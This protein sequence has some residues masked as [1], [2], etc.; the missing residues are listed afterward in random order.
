MSNSLGTLAVDLVANVAQFRKEMKDSSKDTEEAMKRIEGAVELG[1]KALEVLGIGLSIGAFA[2]LIKGSIDA[3][4]ELRDMSQKTGVAVETLNGLAF[5]AGQAGGSMEAMADGATKLNKAVAEAGRGNKDFLEPF[6]K[7]GI[8]IR[9]AS[10]QLKTADVLMAE[11]ADNF[12]KY[13]DGPEKTAIALRIFEDAG[14]NLIPLLNDGGNAM[15]ENIEYAKKYSGVTQDLANASDNFNDTL[16]KLKI[17]QKGFVNSMTTSLLPV[18]QAVADEMLD[19]AEK[20]GKFSL[21]GAVLRTILETIV[22]VGSEA[23]FGFKMMGMAIGGMAAEVK[24]L[25]SADMKGFH[26]ISDALA[27]DIDKAKIEHDAF[28]KRVLNRDIPQIALPETPKSEKPEKPKPHAPTLR[29]TGDDPAQAILD[30]KLK[31]LEGAY[32]K[33]R[34]AA[35]FHAR[36]MQ[37]LR[38]QDLITLIA[39]EEDRQAETK[40]AIEASDKFYDAE[41]AAI[42]KARA[43]AAKDADRTSL[44]NQM[45][46]KV[47]AK[48]KARID[49]QNDAT[50]QTLK[51]SSAQSE[52]N[53]AMKEWTIQQDLSADQF[54]FELSL[55]GRTAL[56]VSK[57]TAARRIDLDVQEQIRQANKNSVTLIDEKPY[58]AAAEKAKAQ[59]SDL[60][61]QQDAQQRDPWASMSESIRKYGEDAS[62]VGAEIGNVMTDAF[63][64]AEDAFVEFAKTGKLS[65]K[66]LTTSV[67]TDLARIEAR[68]AIAGIVSM[69]TGSF[70]IA[71]L[72][73]ITATSGASGPKL[74]GA[75]AA[76][77]TVLG[78]SAYLVGERGPEIFKPAG[79]GTIIPNSQIGGVGGGV[80]ISTVVN[81]SDAGV[82]TSTSGNSSQAGRAL[83]DM[84]NNQVKQIIGREMRQGGLLWK[85]NR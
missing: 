3:A 47:A 26:V 16:G 22:V 55:Y 45:N 21:A 33:E 35:D 27:E 61:D 75:R 30:G 72:F 25:A 77:G 63:Q 59:L 52:L 24:A 15:R 54:R 85:G 13:A 23:V 83:A 2:E 41:I 17:Q 37:D 84:I 82:N 69:A 36:Y 49:L 53:K 7:L 18:L 10:G 4:D 38:S 11:L 46:E 67:L 70:D 31:A 14:A 28:I 42:R 66:D 65:F 50:L 78:G 74:A 32:S 80:N 19:S 60:Y 71:G 29:A 81:V 43:A 62:N 39:Y 68:K 58:L 9:D 8:S 76:G 44:T 56:E 1:K 20:A 5:A 73:G 12:A 40:K 64:G 57:L 51:L 48:E 79:A 6:N 34:A